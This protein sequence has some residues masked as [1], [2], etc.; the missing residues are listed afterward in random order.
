MHGEGAAKQLH[1]YGRRNA[2]TSQR[3][4]PAAVNVL[5]AGCSP[6]GVDL[7]TA[8]S[9]LTAKRRR[10]AERE[11]KGLSPLG[12]RRK[13]G[14]FK[15]QPKAKA[16]S[17]TAAGAGRPAQTST[18]GSGRG[19]AGAAGS[20]RRRSAYAEFLAERWAA[21]KA[22]DPEAVYREAV[23]EIAA[24][25]RGLGGEA[26]QRYAQGLTA[27]PGAAQPA[28]AAAASRSGKGGAGSGVMAGKATAVSRSGA[29][30]AK[31]KP[32]GKGAVGK[33]ATRAANPY[34]VFCRV[35]RPALSAA[36][37]G[38]SLGEM[39]RLLGAAWAALGEEERG[40]YG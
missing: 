1:T 28:E 11:A 40:T 8:V 2:L 38:A 29:T 19:E 20:E 13:A 15:A 25:W 24:Q 30:K 37:P 18:A 26:Q 14:K 32:K 23:S 6:Q 22:Q 16:A 3:V 12:P 35:A 5:V 36:H 27:T 10:A 17:K 34:I 9:L 39:S 31:A 7:E 4:P 21:R 33:A